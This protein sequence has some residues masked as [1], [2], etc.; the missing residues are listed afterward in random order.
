MGRVRKG[1]VG[2]G[3]GRVGRGRVGYGTVWHDRFTK[4]LV[5]SARCLPK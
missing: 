5:M 1:R 3:Y 4:W 2:V